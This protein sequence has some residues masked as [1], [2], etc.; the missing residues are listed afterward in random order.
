MRFLII[1]IISV[2]FSGFTFSADTVV[3]NVSTENSQKSVQLVNV[4]QS[5]MNIID[6]NMIRPD[7]IKQNYQ[8][9]KKEES[10]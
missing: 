5:R 8:I 1:T 2:A 4:A 3:D 10:K 9:Q 7:L 6:E